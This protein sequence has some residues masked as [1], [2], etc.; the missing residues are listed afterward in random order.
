MRGQLSVGERWRIVS[1]RF[2]QGLN[3]SQIARIINCSVQTVY[4]IL[5]LYE[6][7][8]YFIERNGRG[9]HN[10]LNGHEIH[11]LRQILYRYLNAT[12]TNIANILFQ[13]IDLVV[14]PRTVR[15]YR[16]SLGFHAV[17]A[18][19]QPLTNATHAQRRLNFCLSHAN[20]QWHN[21]G[22]ILK[23]DTFSLTSFYY[24]FCAAMPSLHIAI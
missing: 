16:L 24:I 9:H 13:R 18:R 20:D 3:V 10:I 1:L 8:N 4:N 22:F 21:I 5:I 23:R 12:L 6:Q 15:Y 14:S 2:D 17:H 11:T 7:T 19:T